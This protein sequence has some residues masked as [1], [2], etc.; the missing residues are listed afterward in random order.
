MRIAICDTET[1][2]LP[3]EGEVGV[4]EYAHAILDT[5]TMRVAGH[6]SVLCNPG[7]P[8]PPEARAVHHI[9]DA[10]VA[11][12]P[13]LAEVL[14]RLDFSGVHAMC[15][16][17]AAYDRPLVVAAGVEIPWWICTYRCALHLWPDAPSHKN[18]VLRYWRDVEPMWPGLHLRA[19]M[20]SSG[21]MVPHRALYDVCTTAGLLIDLLRTAAERGEDEDPGRALL[22]LTDR[23]VLLGTCR[24]GKHRGTPWSEVPRDYLQWML[25]SGAQMDD[26]DVAHTVRHHLGLPT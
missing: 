9:S 13:P 22:A 1:T 11:G 15:A 3:E 21:A 24:F 6:Y 26:G 7:I 4:V 8:I 16:H 14:G 25:R 10:D 18:Q 2:G 17:N 20:E 19:L 5:E 12:R 23:P